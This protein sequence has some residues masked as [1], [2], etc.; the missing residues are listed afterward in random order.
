MLAL[1]RKRTEASTITLQ[2]VIR[3]A[4]FTGRRLRKQHLVLPRH[5]ALIDGLANDDATNLTGSAYSV[6]LIQR[7]YRHNV[8]KRKLSAEINS[9]IAKKRQERGMRVLRRLVMLLFVAC[10]C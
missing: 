5:F 7:F 9:R 10:C 8:P 2:A 4:M 3:A 1:R 6:S